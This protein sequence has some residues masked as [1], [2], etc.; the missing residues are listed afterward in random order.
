MKHIGSDKVVSRSEYVARNTVVTVGAQTVKTVL[1]FVSRTVFIW[2][3]GKELLGIN[4]LFTEIMTMLSFAELGIGNAFVY[5]LYKPIAANDTEH[6]KS[7]MNLFAKAYKAIGLVVGGLGLAL[8][9]FLKLIVGSVAVS[10]QLLYSV[11]LLYVFNSAFSYFFVYKTSLITANQLNYVVVSVQVVV[12]AVQTVVQ[13]IFLYLTRDFLIYTALNVVATVATNVL[14]A[15]WA[16]RKYPYLRDKDVKPLNSEEREGIVANV[17]ALIVYKIGERIFGSTDNIFIS[18]LINVGTVGMY[19]NYQL[20]SNVFVTLGGQVM[21]SVT[22]SV[23]NANATKSKE[24]NEQ[25]FYGIMCVCAWFFGLTAVGILL[26]SNMFIELWVGADYCLDALSVL[27]IALVLYINNM[28]YPCVTYRYTT[29]IFRYGKWIPIISSILNI[30]LDVVLGTLWGLP[31][32]MLATIFSRIATYEIV[33]PVIIYRH[34]F[35]RNV[36][37]YFLQYA[38]YTAF[39]AISYCACW[40]ILQFVGLSGWYGFIISCLIVLVVYTLVFSALSWKTSGFAVL[41]QLAH[42]LLRRH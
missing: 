5:S 26:L 9:P 6:L 8:L 17:K 21:T 10:D 19:S 14:L 28:H 2:V 34:V 27:C 15:H 36:A 4:S 23:G 3:M 12:Y 25:I 31:G 11:Y 7:L 22:A 41:R 20:I 24:R 38:M 37:S 13:I 33:D 16:D 29:G 35:E 39:V 1:G 40:G 32:I 42:S 30:V 18:A